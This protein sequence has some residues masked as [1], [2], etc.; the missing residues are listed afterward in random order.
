MYHRVEILVFAMFAALAFCAGAAEYDVAAYVWPAY[1]PE[2]RWAELGIFADGKG[3][4]QNLYESTKRMPDDYQG[5]KPLW[6]YED[7]SD[8]VVVARKID[9]ATAAG[10]NVPYTF[11]AAVPSLCVFVLE[12]HTA[13]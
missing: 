7:E 13:S 8:P 5:V 6:G 3:E 9:A 2:P 10:V 12:L 4:W 1:Q 11:S